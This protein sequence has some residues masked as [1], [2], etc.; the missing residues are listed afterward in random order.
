MPSRPTRQMIAFDVCDS[1]N[2]GMYCCK[3]HEE[4]YI[5]A[6]DWVKEYLPAH[7]VLFFYCARD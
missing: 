1:S 6:G 7:A 5:T 2:F 4:E 3:P